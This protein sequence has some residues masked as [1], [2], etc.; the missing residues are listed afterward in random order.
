MAKEEPEKKKSA[1]LQAFFK[2]KPTQKKRAETPAV[3]RPIDESKDATAAKKP[4]PA[5]V[6]A[7]EPTTNA[8]GQ[9]TGQVPYAA[10]AATFSRIE[11]TTKRLEIQSIVCELLEQTI[12]RAPNDLEAILFLLCNKVAPAFDNLEMGIGDSLLQ[13][14]IARAFGKEVK[15]VK[16]AY[17]REG[18]LGLVAE[19]ARRKQ[20]FLGFGS[21]PKPLQASQVLEAYRAICSIS[22]SKSQDQ[23]VGKMQKLMIS[24]TPVEAKY[25]TRGLQGKLRI[26][27]AETSVLIAFAHALVRSP[28]VSSEDLMET[29]EKLPSVTREITG[30]QA[31]VA[32]KIDAGRGNALGKK[33]L[34]K[35]ERLIAAEAVVKQCYAEAPSYS[36]LCQGAL[37]TPLWNLHTKCAL[38]VG[39]PVFPM[40]AKPTKSVDEVLKRLSGKAFT[41]EHKYDGERFQAHLASDGS[42]RVFSRNLQDTTKKW[43]EV[44]AVLRE[45]CVDG[46]TSFVLDAE[47]VAVDTAT[48]ALLPFQ[49]LSTRKKEVT[50]GESGGPAVIV[51]AFD[52]LLLN[53]ESLLRNT[54]RERRTRLHASFK[55]VKNG[56]AFA[57]SVD[58]DGDGDDVVAAEKIQQALEEAIT[59][60]SEGLMVKTLDDNATYEPSKRSLNWLKLKK[61]YLDGVGDS[62]DL[63]VVG[64]YTG[65]GKRTGVFGAYL[66]ACLDAESG[67]LQ[68]VC[69]IGT[70]F[71]DDDLKK[72]HEESQ[73]LIIPKK[74]ANVVCG[75]AL[76]QDIVWLEPKMVWEVQVADLSLSDTHKGALGRVNAG[77]G[78]GLRFPRLLRA[79][80]DKAAD[81][82]TTSDQVLELYLNQDSVKG[83]AQVDDDDDDGYL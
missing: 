18:D 36:T 81:Q 45:A 77:R 29:E 80:D 51:L 31:S 16:S 65:R 32:L 3:K 28:P 20:K 49:R 69:K 43:P 68:S 11:A 44:A 74:A 47:V 12:A 37:T 63:V 22:G 53:G 2:P 19:D 71:S 57:D 34:T 25:V 26:G 1:T 78:I 21:K 61:D 62:L 76:E 24:A 46:T 56:F 15:N 39:V 33:R 55:A 17:E 4:K 83:T 30:A 75:D 66:C 54:L 38:G 5:P 82:A 35:D 14:A 7:K 73:P 42:V 8:D 67:D 48:G 60:K 79:R 72:F 40:L 27:L 50:E 59:A 13:K 41:C 6:V 23:K 52:L 9:W 10:V 70:G 64:A 58:V